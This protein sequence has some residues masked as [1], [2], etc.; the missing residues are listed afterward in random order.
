MGEVLGFT[1]IQKSRKDHVCEWCGQAIPK[2]D[3]YFRWAWAEDGYCSAVKCHLLCYEAY[4]SMPCKE[5]VFFDRDFER[6]LSLTAA[7]AVG[8]YL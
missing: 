3:S 7:R 8:E 2:G 5:P 4:L 6:P 1:L